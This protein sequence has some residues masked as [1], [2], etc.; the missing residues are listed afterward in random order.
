MIVG[1]KFWKD[2]HD[3]IVVSLVG[4]QI[5]NLSVEL[6]GVNAFFG[7]DEREYCQLGY[8]AGNRYY[9]CVA[10]NY[11]CIQG[12]NIN[13]KLNEINK[14]LAFLEMNVHDEL[15]EIYKKEQLK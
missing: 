4:L 12:D 3:K 5:D 9:A 10:E 13:G 2:L 11:V 8:L 6:F 15:S 1:E 14:R 7:N